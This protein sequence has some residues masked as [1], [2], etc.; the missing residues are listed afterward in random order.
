M[1]G[2]GAVDKKDVVDI[3]MLATAGA[4]SNKKFSESD[5]EK[6]IDNATKVQK[7]TVK[8]V[9]EALKITKKSDGENVTSTEDTE[10]TK[11]ASKEPEEVVEEV[12]TTTTKKVKK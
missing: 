10:T 5:V 7:K 6:A 3:I 11:K 9:Q 4:S 1:D 12:V 8:E 2:D